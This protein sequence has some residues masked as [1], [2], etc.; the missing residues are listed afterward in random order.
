MYL[1]ANKL[2]S[3]LEGDAVF[4]L[5]VCS[6]CRRPWKDSPEHETITASAFKM[7]KNSRDPWEIV[8]L[9]SLLS[10][11]FLL[12]IGKTCHCV[13]KVA[14]RCYS[15]FHVSLAN[16]LDLCILEKVRKD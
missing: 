4:T 3:T 16:V 13:I 11:M 5:H 6:L 12:P 9:Q 1:I 7:C 8:S 10:Y 2:P 14:S 15:G